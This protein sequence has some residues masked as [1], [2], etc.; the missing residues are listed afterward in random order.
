MKRI[1]AV[2]L[3]VTLLSFVPCV[4]QMIISVSHTAI[5]SNDDIKQLMLYYR[6][7]KGLVVQMR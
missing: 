7:L 2:L 5:K 1:V 6:Y 3:V 4:L